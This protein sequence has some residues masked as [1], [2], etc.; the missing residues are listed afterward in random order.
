MMF[1]LLRNP[2]LFRAVD[3]EM[4]G[5]AVVWNSVVILTANMNFFVTWRRVCM[6]KVF[7][8]VLWENHEN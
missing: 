2:I 6:I 5:Y 3:V 4:S 7:K 8:G 1:A